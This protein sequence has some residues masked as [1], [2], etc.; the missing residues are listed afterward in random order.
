VPGWRDARRLSAA[1]ACAWFGVQAGV[2][3]LGTTSVFAVLPGPQAGPIVG[4][5]LGGEAS[6][7]IVLGGVLIL[8]ERLIGRDAA[9]H[10]RGSAFSVEFVLALGAVF[11]AVAGHHALQPYLEQARAGRGPLSFGQ[12]HAISVAFYLLKMGLVG[13]LAWRAIARLAASRP[14]LAPGGTAG[15]E[16]NLPPASSG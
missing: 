7:A 15:A 11:C 4:R 10:G 6:L 1:L 12:L 13:A 9:S 16:V 2:A 5:M 8:L 3:G 14:P